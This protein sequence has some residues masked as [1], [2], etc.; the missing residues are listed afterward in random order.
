MTVDRGTGLK[1]VGVHVQ[2]AERA[3]RGMA[4]NVLVEVLETEAVTDG[5]K[6]AGEVR[7]QQLV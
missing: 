1:L 7:P 2:A 4:W 5:R 3:A 6:G